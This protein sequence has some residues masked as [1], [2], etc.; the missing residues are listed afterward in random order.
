MQTS[1]SK[2]HQQR[3]DS[4]DA[5]EPEVRKHPCR[6]TVRTSGSRH[7]RAVQCWRAGVALELTMRQ[8][9]ISLSAGTGPA[10][11]RHNRIA[12]CADADRPVEGFLSWRGGRAHRS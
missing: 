5:F 11:F 8:K 7:Y 6:P 1:E 4:S 3:Y 10:L 2:G 9:R 12:E